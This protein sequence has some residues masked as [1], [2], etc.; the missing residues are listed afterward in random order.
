MFNSDRERGND[1]HRLLAGERGRGQPQQTRNLALSVL[2]TVTVRVW[3]RRLTCSRYEMTTLSVC[4]P[5]RR[6]ATRGVSVIGT[7]RAISFAV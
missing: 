1:L 6:P 3:P 2:V 7:C 4:D 5:E